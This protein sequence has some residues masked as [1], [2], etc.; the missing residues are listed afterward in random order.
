M[1]WSQAVLSDQHRCYFKKGTASLDFLRKMCTKMRTLF[2]RTFIESVLTFCVVVWFGNLN[3][4]DKNRLDRL[5]RVAS[6][7]IGVNQVQL[8]ELYVW[9]VARKTQAILA[10]TDHPL[11]GEFERLPSGRRYR[12]PT[13]RTKMFGDSF[14][15]FAIG[16]LN[17][18]K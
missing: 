1:G 18:H 10:C 3:L 9:Q 7:V 5:V 14:V 6:K 15:C 4:A 13:H 16:R 8:S 2:Y 17:R 12:A 11:K